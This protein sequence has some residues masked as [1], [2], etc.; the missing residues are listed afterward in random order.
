MLRF[1]YINQEYREL[2]LNIKR[3]FNN[4][5]AT[6]FDKRN[7]IKVVEFEGKKFV[8]KS[9]KLPNPINSVAYRYFRKSKAK[10]SYEN[11]IELLKRGINVPKPIGYVEF[12][13][14]VLRKSF[15]ISEL[16]EFDFEI[17]DVL[18]DE[19]FED[20]KRILKEFTKFSYSLHQ[21]GIY[22]LDYSPGNIL[23][24]KKGGN[25]SFALVDLNR[26]KFLNFSDELRFKSLSRFSASNVDIELIAKEYAELSGITEE[27]AKNALNKYH[28][29]H[30]EYLQRKKRLKKIKKLSKE[31][32]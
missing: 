31:G 14:L 16:L 27:F 8:V 26:V 32:R 30:Q 17:R 21:K 22:H 3:W 25:Y 7:V 4:S 20:R 19:D 10:R 2:V 23:I 29:K 5:T 9:F 13:G 6:L 24:T 28:Q 18:R 1:E 11:S 12:G 15:F